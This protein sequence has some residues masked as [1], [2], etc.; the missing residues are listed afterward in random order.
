M[1]EITR[2]TI[3]WVKV[4]GWRH[5]EIVAYVDAKSLRRDLDKDLGY[6][7]ML[8]SREYPVEITINGKKIE[9]NSVARYLVVDCKNSYLV[10]IMDLY[11]NTPELPIITDI[12]VAKVDQGTIKP[13]ELSKKDPTYKTFCPEYI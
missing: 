8:F 13:I 3:E 9:V 11:F 5:S 6:G 7:V 4:S 1:S 2:R 10:P 12:S